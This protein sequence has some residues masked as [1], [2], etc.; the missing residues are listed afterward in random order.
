M[1]LSYTSVA[2]V[3]SQ[4]PLIGSMTTLSSAQTFTFCEDAEALVNAKIA[5][6]YTIP[7]TGSGVPPLLQS[8]ATNIA[9]YYVLARRVFTQERLRDSGWP[10][11]FKEAIDTLDEISTG[12][13]K[14]VDTAGTLL[15]TRSDVHDVW[16]NKKDYRP[17]FDE[18]GD[19]D[20]IIDEDKID[21]LEDD[22]GI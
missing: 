7:A 10:D 1:A 6:N 13:L 20:Q 4:H 15:G 9:V 8:L 11:R 18:H 22:R 14:L 16:S 21:D 2:R 3:R 19:Y 12:K 5:P 17:T